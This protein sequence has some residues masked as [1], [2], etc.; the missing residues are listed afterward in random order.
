MDEFASPTAACVTNITQSPRSSQCVLKVWQYFKGK[1]GDPTLDCFDDV[2]S[3]LHQSETIRYPDLIILDR[4]QVPPDLV[5]VPE[6]V[7]GQHTPH[8]SQRLVA[9]FVVPAH[10]VQVGR[11]YLFPE[12]Q[13]AVPQ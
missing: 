5:D 11:P 4:F 12:R 3:N 2:V 9:P 8:V 1:T 6:V 10:S 7:P 13:I